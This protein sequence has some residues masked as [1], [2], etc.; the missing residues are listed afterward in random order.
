MAGQGFLPQLATAVPAFR[1]HFWVRERIMVPADHRCCRL[2]EF[3]IYTSPGGI[4]TGK[5]VQLHFR[6][7]RH[8]ALYGGNHIA[9]LAHAGGLNQNAVGVK[10]P[11][12]VLQRL[13]EVAHQGA[14]DAPGGHL[15]DLDPGVL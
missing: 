15:G 8:R 14:A 4:P 11:L 6:G 1:G 10:L 12:H 5:A 9:E 2:A 3:F 7:L 13:A